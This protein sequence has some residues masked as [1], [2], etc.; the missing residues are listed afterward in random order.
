MVA[1]FE[2]GDLM[3]GWGDQEAEVQLPKKYQ[4]MGPTVW[5]EMTLLSPLGG[6]PLLI[7]NMKES[8]ESMTGFCSLY[9]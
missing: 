2:E 9:L 3:E 7:A 4:F 8:R 5:E 1:N 6:R